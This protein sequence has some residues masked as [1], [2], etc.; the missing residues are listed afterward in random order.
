MH[1]KEA[2]AERKEKRVLRACAVQ[3]LRLRV[4]G[5]S[6]LWSKRSVVKAVYG[7]SGRGLTC[8]ACAL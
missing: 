5:Q 4:C 3:D 7:Q 2:G 8:G 1:E 6:G